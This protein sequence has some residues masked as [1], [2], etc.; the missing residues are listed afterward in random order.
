MKISNLLGNNLLVLFLLSGCAAIPTVDTTISTF[1]ATE[2]RNAGTIS[3]VAT[4]AEQNDSLEFR[5]YK[6]R[7][8]QNLSSHGYKITSNPSDAEY[9]A[10]V[11]YGIDEGKSG[12]VTTPVYGL[13]GG[14]TTFTS[15]GTSSYTMPSYGAVASS[16]NSVTT[17][18]RAIALD[19]VKADDFKKGQPKKLFELRA[20]SVGSCSVIAGVFEEILEAMFEDFPGL[21]GKAKK[22]TVTF[23]GSC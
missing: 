11:A 4:T 21:S 22:V 18:I 19:I 20:K 5:H 7:F 9:I 10:L 16:T 6:A 23:K 17:Y 14:G 13:T 12:V 2:Y 15:Y 1:Y 8:E 3:V